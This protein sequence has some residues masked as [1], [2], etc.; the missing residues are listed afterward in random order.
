MERQGLH[1]IELLMHTWWW[2]A[3]AALIQKEVTLRVSAT[4]STLFIFIPFLKNILEAKEHLKLT[5][6]LS[7]HISK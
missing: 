2:R 6:V 1:P 7:K 3:G 5:V 4:A